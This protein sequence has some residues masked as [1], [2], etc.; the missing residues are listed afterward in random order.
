M[1][2]VKTFAQTL[3][4]PVVAVDALTILENSVFAMKG[5]KVI[6][7]IDALR[8]EIY[9]KAVK[10][11]LKHIDK[12]INENKKNKNKIIIVGNA[13]QVYKEKLSRNLGKICISLPD[14]MHM[15][16]GFCAWKNSIRS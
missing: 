2:A 7:A 3:N 11:I 5:I 15:P 8:D 16:E 12:F 9:V 6:A 14:M 10:I 13:A 1:T 4:R